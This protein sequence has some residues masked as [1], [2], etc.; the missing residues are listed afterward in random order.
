[1]HNKYGEIII[2]KYETDVSDKY[3]KYKIKSPFN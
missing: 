2:L 1:M 3:K